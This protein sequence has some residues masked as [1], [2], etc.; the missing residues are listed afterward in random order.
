MRDSF[1]VNI[2]KRLLTCVVRLHALQS[3]NEDTTTGQVVSLVLG[4]DAAL[5][6]ATG[7]EG[8]AHGAPGVLGVGAEVGGSVLA[9]NEARRGLGELEVYIAAAVDGRLDVV[10][11]TLLVEGQGQVVS[12][13]GGHALVEH[14]VGERVREPLVVTLSAE[15]ENLHVELGGGVDSTVDEK[16]RLVIPYFSFEA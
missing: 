2:C 1:Y 3:H 13:E 6:G 14:E 5:D 15:V 10:G 8:M 12:T 16:S 11:I 4:S 7:P 9:D